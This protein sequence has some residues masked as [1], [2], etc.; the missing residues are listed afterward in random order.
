MGESVVLEKTGWLVLRSTA[1]NLNSVLR[2]A[3]V[4]GLRVHQ[5]YNADLPPEWHVKS[6]LLLYK[7]APDRG[8]NMKWNPEN[9]SHSFAQEDPHPN[10]ENSIMFCTQSMDNASATQGLLVSVLNIARGASQS[11]NLGPELTRLRA[12]MQP[13]DP[14][15]RSAAICSSEVVRNAH[16]KAAHE[17]PGGHPQMLDEDDRLQTIILADELWMYTVLLPDAAGKV[18]YELQG[19]ADQAKRVGV[20][21]GTDQDDWLPHGIDFIKR[22]ATTFQEHNTPFLFFAVV[23][24]TPENSTVRAANKRKSTWSDG[25]SSSPELQQQSSEEEKEGSDVAPAE[26]A[27]DRDSDKPEGGDEVDGETIREEVQRIRATHNYDAFF[28]EFLK[29]LASRGDLNAMIRAQSE[30][31][32]GPESDRYDD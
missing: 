24:D 22:K 32:T 12:F 28:T 1:N 21:E 11:F 20:C 13:M 17:Q 3:G 2:N 6:F 19:V 31:G 5:I 30:Y 18:V 7:W 25:D 9:M 23:E 14:I 8:D 27:A 26:S 16:N 4:T 15:L 29:L 10:K